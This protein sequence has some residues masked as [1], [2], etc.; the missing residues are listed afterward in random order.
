MSGFS[1]WYS[2]K[3]KKFTQ[4]SVFLYAY[5]TICRRVPAAIYENRSHFA[6]QWWLL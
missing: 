2:S 3:R 1:A 6:R 4:G 5:Q